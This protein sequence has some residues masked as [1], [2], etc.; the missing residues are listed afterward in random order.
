MYIHTCIHASNI[1]YI[2]IYI[3]IYI[4]IYVHVD[5]EMVFFCWMEVAAE[6]PSVG[7]NNL[8][9]TTTATKIGMLATHIQFERVGKSVLQ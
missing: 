8:L 7:E 5:S 4:Y 6:T 2:H 3:Y 9:A 1:R